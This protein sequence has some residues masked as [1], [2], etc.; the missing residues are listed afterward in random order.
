MLPYLLD[1]NVWLA[2]TWDVH[3]HHTRATKWFGSLEAA[4][5]RFLFCRFTMLGFLRLL[6][7]RQVM[8]ESTITVGEAVALYD[9]WLEDPRVELA[10]ERQG[11]EMALRQSLAEFAKLNATKAVADCYLVAFAAAYDATLVT[12]DRDLAVAARSNSVAVALLT[13]RHGSRR[14]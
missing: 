6:T 5:V 13:P 1:I 12:L 11:V 7:N 10:P 14:I 2:L 3:P 8:G 9:R 4:R